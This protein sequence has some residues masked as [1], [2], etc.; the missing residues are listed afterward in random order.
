M[1]TS[2]PILLAALLLL[3]GC[4]NGSSELQI[5]GHSDD[6]ADGSTADAAAD[7]TP[8]LVGPHGYVFQPHP[9]AAPT[10]PALVPLPPPTGAGGVLTNEYAE[11]FN[12]LNEE[13]GPEIV[14]RD[15]VV[16]VRCTEAQTA[17]PDVDGQ[18]LIEPPTDL[19][20]PNDPFSEVQMYHH[21]NVI[22]DYFKDTLGVTEMD[23]PL[24]AITNQQD[25]YNEAAAG[26]NAGWQPVDN[27]AFYFPESF[28][29]LGLEPRE[30]GAIIFGQGSMVDFSYDASVIYHEYTHAVIGS[31]RLNGIFLADHGVDQFSGAV[32]EGLADYFA[33][34]KLDDALVGPYG[35]AAF[36][37]EVARD[38]EKPRRCPDDLTTEVHAD[39]KIIGSAMWALRVELGAETTDAIIYRG[40]TTLSAESSL[41]AFGQA[42]LAE[43]NQ[44]SSEVGSVVE[45][46]LI[47]YGI[48]GCSFS[49]PWA[50]FDAE[51]T[52][53]KIPFQV[54]GLFQ[55]SFP[56][57]TEWAPGYIQFNV[58]V[59]AGKAAVLSWEILP[60]FRGLR[61]PLRLAVRKESLVKLAPI[62]DRIDLIVDE[63]IDVDY[64]TTEPAVQIVTLSGACVPEGGGV[65]H[66]LFLNTSRGPAQISK[67]NVEFIDD[68]TDAVNLQDCLLD[69]IP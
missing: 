24:P 47:D 2:T 61:D 33:A 55:V 65:V 63:V 34:S 38:L 35:L 5:F 43:A 45:G 20:D 32:N 10:Q 4:S 6:A 30:R 7:T 56:G 50:A 31:D 11:V 12:C 16:G 27:A 68:T 60:G 48:I 64:T 44:V 21:V 69:P 53:D 42:V 58:E 9:N 49:R 46:T 23:Y 51:Q 41:E 22:H 14:F 13:D 62:G 26:E 8:A 17:V 25:Y 57:L 59:P 52:E 37:E 54:P 40:I 66:T 19:I 29:A 28:E 3:G 39:G 67:M 15:T 18:Y 1:K 36:G